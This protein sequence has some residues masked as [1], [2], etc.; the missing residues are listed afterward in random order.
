MIGKTVSHYRIIEKRVGARVPL[1]KAATCLGGTGPQVWMKIRLAAAYARSGAIQQELQ[2]LDK[3]RTD[4]EAGNPNDNSDI[5]CLEG[6]VELAKGNFAKGIE[7]VTPA[8]R[9]HRT[10]A[11]A[12]SIAPIE[13]QRTSTK[14]LLRTSPS[15]ATESLWD[16]K[17]SRDGWKHITGWPR[18]TSSVGK[19]KKHL[20][21]SIG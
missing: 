20:H 17:R 14:P 2:I 6:E 16:G 7:L 8:D 5:H 9:E 19:R 12:E 11:T 13:W 4:A 10:A 3:A 18:F 15:C 21:G 1:D